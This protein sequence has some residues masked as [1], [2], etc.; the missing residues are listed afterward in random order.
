MNKFKSIQF[1][2]KLSYNK[3]I[4]EGIAMLYTYIAIKIHNSK[5]PHKSPK[6]KDCEI[7]FKL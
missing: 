7:L 6:R 2:W 3:Y 1:G 4:L 5:G